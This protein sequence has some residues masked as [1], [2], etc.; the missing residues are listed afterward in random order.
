MILNKICLEDFVSH[1][2]TEIKLDY[3]INVIVGPNGAGKTSI[4]DAISFALFNDT[5][6][7]KKENIINSKSSRCIVSLEFTEAGVRYE[8]NWSL[9]RRGSAKGSL[10]RLSET[11]RFLQVKGGERVVVSEIEKVLGIDKS[12]FLQSV[13]VRQGEIEELVTAIP[14]ARKALISR[15]LGVDELDRACSSIKDVIEV[16]KDKGKLLEGEL[17]RKSKVE[18]QKNL[19]IQKSAELEKL[20]DSKKVELAGIETIIGDLQKR[21]DDLKDKKSQFDLLDREKE[22]LDQKLE[23]LKSRL[24]TEKGELKKAIAAENIVKSLEDEIKKLP[25]IEVYAS[26]LQNKETLESKQLRLKEKFDELIELEKTIEVNW[27]KYS[28]YLE[29][30]ELIN[31]KLKERRVYEGADAALSN[32]KSQLKN[33]Q[34]LV[35][36]RERSLEGELE[37]CS[38]ALGEV[39]TV[40]T[41]ESIFDKVKKINQESL[42]DF[43]L[44]IREITSAKGVLKQRILELEEN[45]SKLSGATDKKSC[46]TCETELGPERVSDLLTKYTSAKATAE[47]QLK[48]VSSDLKKTSKEQ[49][50]VEEKRSKVI[51][52][53][54][55]R[56]LELASEVEDAKTQVCSQEIEL[57][58]LKKKAEFLTTLTGCLEQLEQEKSVLEDAAKEFEAAKRR[59]D[60]LPS[61][62]SLEEEAAPIES[63]L[64]ESD[65][66]LSG[67]I[68]ILGY[69][70]VDVA[71]ELK[72]LRKL[73]EEFDRNLPVAQ[74]KGEYDSIVLATDKEISQYNN[75]WSDVIRKIEKLAYDL[76]IHN[77]TQSEFDSKNKVVIQLDKD[78]VEINAKKTGAENDVKNYSLELDALREKAS[79]KKFVDK[80]IA[81]LNKIRDAYGKDG[82]QKLIRARAKPLLEKA[83]RDLFE[84]FNLAYSDVKIDED[85]NI[86]VIGPSGEQDINQIS[87]GERVALA[88][89]LRLAIAQVLS[90][91]IETIIMDEPTTH[92]DEQRRKELV[93]ILSSFFREG[94]RIIP[95]MLIITH[96]PEIEDVADTIYTIRKEDNYSIAEKNLLS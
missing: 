5:C 76:D 7:G 75:S 89:A 80:Y 91:K 58:E 93:N 36:K 17:S 8:S 26:S 31:D 48:E 21:L 35:K 51:S 19:A 96:H 42:K 52:V 84:R 85:Y 56:V 18:E 11:D 92:L 28:T 30:Q 47:K 33:L 63:G 57:E 12:M 87:G 34:D 44:K 46:P 45:I 86:S 6:R 78:L 70:P 40:E 64:K 74:R 53:S 60:R 71:S 37:K 23:G 4:L 83:T 32:A 62:E 24:E 67:C 55:Q 61:K 15:L 73:K 43:D 88:I 68:D 14:S 9:E 29:K 65:S 2:K 1:K 77:Q 22:L 66:S 38:D 25:T 81:V 41:V 95:Q 50:E 82:I 79:E 39:V 13:Y 90:G 3:G 69:Q 72:K 27:K 59:I 10:S 49:A 94:G 20:L 16:Y 54:P